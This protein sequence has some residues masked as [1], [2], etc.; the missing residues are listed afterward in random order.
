[1]ENFIFFNKFQVYFIY[2]KEFLLSSIFFSSFFLS[3]LLSPSL[4][5]LFFSSFK[6]N[7]LILV[8]RWD[9][10]VKDLDDYST[11]L[12][13]RSSIPY[14]VLYCPLNTFFLFFFYVKRNDLAIIELYNPVYLIERNISTHMHIYKSPLYDDASKRPLN[15]SFIIIS[16]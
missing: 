13:Q 9:C 16:L 14:L 8:L 10:T 7:L 6:Y 15:S 2:I 12:L 11:L 3:F 1:M 5:F 4:F